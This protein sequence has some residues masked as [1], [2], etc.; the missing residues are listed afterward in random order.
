VKNIVV[1]SLF[2][3]AVGCGG[4]DQPV[5]P[6]I[7]EPESAPAGPGSVT[8]ADGVP[9]AYTVSGSGSPALVFI[10]GWMCNQGFWAAQVSAFAPTHAV[11]T[12]D[13]AG[14]GASGMVRE[15]WPLMAFGGDVQAAVEQLGL[16]RVILVGHSMGGPVAL[17]AARLMPDRVIGVVAVDALQNADFELDPERTAELLAMW[18]RDFAGT[19][20]GF[21]TSMF[22]ETAEP[23]LVDRVES[24][25]CSAPAESSVAQLRQFLGYDMKRA[26]SAVEVPVRCINAD[27]YPTNVEGN[28]AYHPD[29]DAVVMTG[30][31]HFL[32]MEQPEVFNRHLVEIVAE[33][34]APQ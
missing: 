13:L 2:L 19:C 7:E 23:A 32:M 27:G 30:V 21:V 6:A 29:F 17:E 4:V 24:E 26:F 28:R 9:I 25:M 14:H 18:D 11:V 1:L 16:D 34:D 12:I 20:S 33:I 15:G 10:H 8:A 3:I 5:A 31:G 22:P